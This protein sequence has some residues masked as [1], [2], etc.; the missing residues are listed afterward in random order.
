MILDILQLVSHPDT[1]PAAVAGVT[2]SLSWQDAGNWVASFI[3]ATPPERLKLPPA[4]TPARTDGL[5][6]RTCFEIFLRD[7][8][9]GAY[10]EFNFSPSGEWAA[11]R[12]TGYREGVQPLDLRDPWITSTDPDQFDAGM[13]ARLT[14]LGIDP[15]VVE[16]MLNTP[17]PPEVPKLPETPKQYAINA[18][19]EDAGLAAPRDWEMGISAVIEE[20][21]GT[22]SYWALKHPAGKPDFHHPDCFALELPAPEAP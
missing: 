16:V 15:S 22:K 13:R 19:L 1:P 14:A 21:D 7:P 20:A 8:G 11:Y 12:F 6:Q 3:V 2:C 18:H 17:M 10:L 4:A 9:T 5:W